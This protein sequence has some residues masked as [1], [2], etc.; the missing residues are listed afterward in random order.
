MK[1]VPL[2]IFAL[3]SVAAAGAQAQPAPQTVNVSL[4]S[5]AFTP[6]TITLKA[7]TTYR[8]HLSDDAGKGHDFSAPEFFAA[9]AVAPEDQAKIKD[10]AVDLEG[11]EAADITV[12]PQKPGTYPLT[13]THFMHSMMGMSGQIVV[14]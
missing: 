13:C 10:G 5:Y 1:S 2:A 4:T 12:T 6:S 8:L 9:S 7:G 3:L 11:G 14:Q